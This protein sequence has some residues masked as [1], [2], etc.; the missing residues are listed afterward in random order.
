MWH[1]WWIKW[2]WDKYLSE[3]FGFSPVNIIPP[4]LS[5]LMY[6]LGDEQ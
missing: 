1:L 5:M 2:H 6:N 4:W 3:F